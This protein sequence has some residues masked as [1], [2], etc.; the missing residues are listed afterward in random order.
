MT[1]LT[2]N[3]RTVRVIFWRRFFEWLLELLAL[4]LLPWLAHLI[5]SG[6]TDSAWERPELYLFVMV[7]SVT[8]VFDVLKDRSTI[9]VSKPLAAVT[10]I[11]GAVLA[12]AAYAKLSLPANNVSAESPGNQFI[13][14][15]VVWIIMASLVVYGVYRV[16]IIAGQAKGEAE[17]AAAEPTVGRGGLR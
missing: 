13:Q 11:V 10:G 5:V 7:I 17:A 6:G 2:V 15:S 16:P 12:P 1:S 14:T 3:R 9:N 4:G 8:S